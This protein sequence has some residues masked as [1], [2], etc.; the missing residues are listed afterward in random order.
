MPDILYI[1]NVLL[2]YKNY[3]NNTL[4]LLLIVRKL[5]EGIT[6]GLYLEQD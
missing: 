2:C 3:T 4:L 1:L 5:R 6:R